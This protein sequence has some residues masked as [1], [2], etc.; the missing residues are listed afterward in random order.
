DGMIIE[1]IVQDLNVS[2]DNNPKSVKEAR[3]LREVTNESYNG[4]S[5]KLEASIKVWEVLLVSRLGMNNKGRMW[6][7]GGQDTQRRNLIKDML[8]MKEEPKEEELL[9]KELLKLVLLKVPRKNNMYSVDMYNIVPKES[10]TCLVAK[11]TLDESMLW[12]RRLGHINFKNINKLVKDNLVRGLPSKRFEND[13]TCVACLKGNQH[14]AS[15]KFEVQNSISQPLFMM[16]MDLYGPTFMSSLM[17]K[18]YGLVITDDY[19][20][21]TWVFFL[22]S[23]DE[24]SGILKKFITEIE[25]LVDKKVKNRVLVVKPHNKTLYELF[26]GR[27]PVLSFMRPFGCPVTILNTLDHLGKFDGKSN[28]GFFVGYSLNGKAFRVYNLRTRKVKENLHIRFLENKPGIADNGP[29]WLFDI[30]MLTKSMNYVPVISCTNFNDFAS[31]KD[32]ID[33]GQSNMETGSNQDYIFKLLWK[34]GSPLFD[35]SP[36]ITGDAGKKHDEVSDKE[37]GASNELNY[38]FE[39]LSTESPNDPKM[40]G[41]ETIATYDDSEEEANLTNLGSS[42]Q[43]SPTPTTR[44]YKNHTL[45]QMEPKKVTQALDDKSWV[46]AM[47]EELLQFKLLNV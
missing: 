45:K 14:K 18:K 3:G 41:L 37:S 15:Y 13:Q 8:P 30:D 42:I 47:Q 40:P 38:A 17:H 5:C 28:D 34:D 25:S 23:K 9:V 22:A 43:V 1:S 35:S 6:P 36:K 21:C 19:S 32:S 46:E 4:E 12:H 31:T 7:L 20:R 39:N 24:T 11:A 10:L 16:H 26:R 27:T 44:I 33:A 2:N 29:E